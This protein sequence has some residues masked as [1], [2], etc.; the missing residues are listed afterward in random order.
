MFSRYTLL[1]VVLLAT[2]FTLDGLGTVEVLAQE[3]PPPNLPPIPPP[4]EPPPP[5][6]NLT[7]PRIVSPR[8]GSTVIANGTEAEVMVVWTEV[9]NAVDY[10]VQVARDRSFANVVDEVTT[11]L[12]NWNFSLGY[13][14]YWARVRANGIYS[15]SNWS[16]PVVFYVAPPPPEIYEPRNNS[17]VPTQLGNNATVHFRWERLPVRY[18]VLEIYDARGALIERLNVTEN[19]ASVELGIGAYTAKLYAIADTNISSPPSEVSFTVVGYEPIEVVSPRGT[20]V[21]DPSAGLNVEIPIT[22]SYRC[23]P[24]ICR[25]EVEIQIPTSYGWRTLK[26]IDLGTKKS[27][28]VPFPAPEEPGSSATY[29][30]VAHLYAKDVEASRDESI[31]ELKRSTLRIEIIN[32]TSARVSSYAVVEIPY[33]DVIDDT[34]INLVHYNESILEYG[35]KLLM[36][37]NAVLGSADSWVELLVLTPDLRRL[38]ESYTLRI[39]DAIPELNKDNLVDRMTS[40]SS[41]VHDGKYLYLAMTEDLDGVEVGGVYVDSVIGTVITKVDLEAMNIVWINALMPN[42]TDPRYLANPESNHLLGVYLEPMGLFELPNGTLLLVEQLSIQYSE[43]LTWYSYL[44]VYRVNPENGSVDEALKLFLGEATDVS[45]SALFGKWLLVSVDS[46]DSTRLLA[47]DVD[48]GVARILVPTGIPYDT[49]TVNI[50]S[51]GSYALWLVQGVPGVNATHYLYVIVL[52]GN[53][54]LVKSYMVEPARRDSDVEVLDCVAKSN[55]AYILVR[56]GC[57]STGEELVGEYL[58]I[59]N[60]SSGEIG[61]EMRNATFTGI[62]YGESKT[63]EITSFYSAELAR[64]RVRGDVTEVRKGIVS[65]DTVVEYLNEV[66]NKVVA[67]K[68]IGIEGSEVVVRSATEVPSV[69]M[70]RIE[71][72]YLSKRDW[73]YDL[74]VYRLYEPTELSSIITFVRSNAGIAMRVSKGTVLIRNGSAEYRDLAPLGIGFATAYLSM[75]G[76]GADLPLGIY[77]GKI[78]VVASTASITS[79]NESESR[80]TILLTA[81]GTLWVFSAKPIYMIYKDGKELCMGNC[82]ELLKNGLYVFDPSNVTISYQSPSMSTSSSGGKSASQGAPSSATPSSKSSSSTPGSLTSQKESGGAGSSILGGEAS[83][84]Y[85]EMLALMLLPAIAIALA[86]IASVTPRKSLPR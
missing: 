67:A 77:G 70:D 45:G 60:A 44:Y 12:T 31:L 35:D 78:V 65:L 83:S 59:I 7:A 3:V 58:M 42:V 16:K 38:E 18:Y 47:L 36:L 84:L 14:A 26:R 41:Y 73:G 51:L 19:E 29:R 33:I 17:A 13:G 62:R 69:F 63:V 5:E 54:D 20:V 2:L 80:V 39:Y 76:G 8:N 32:A 6:E 55:V 86:L 27:V 1:L 49:A 79:V 40:Y 23:V 15:H 4:I 71:K 72:V 28:T 46:I 22:V 34:S 52:S 66:E 9:Y 57:G 56:E 50:V 74:A 11:Y 81:P 10:T 82:S 24:N 53:L 21:L 68:G 48:S 75:G 85:K 37:T 43:P 30:I 61:V 64:A 25:A